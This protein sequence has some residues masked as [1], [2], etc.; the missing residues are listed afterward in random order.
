MR[1]IGLLLAFLAVL[2]S[3]GCGPVRP[4]EGGTPVSSVALANVLPAPAGL[5]TAEPAGPASVEE[6]QRELAGRPDA[7][8]VRRLEAADLREG[9]IRRWEGADGAR[10]TA[11]I[12]RWSSRI[13]ATNVG[14]A[15]AEQLLEE[16]GARAWTPPEIPGSRGA[17]LDGPAPRLTLSRSVG[18]NGIFLRAEGPVEERAVARLM[19]LA[20]TAAE[21]GLQAG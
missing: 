16:P 9:A 18:P 14:A 15:A 11:V 8:G 2:A 10:V 13:L 19:E 21:G 12:T 6:I 4:G 20:V 17:R 7:E 1:T 5:E 3:L